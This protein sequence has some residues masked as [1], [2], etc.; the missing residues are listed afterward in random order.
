MSPQPSPI[1]H[2]RITAK[3]GEGGMGEVWRA[4]D[5]KLNREV[6]IKILPEAFAADPNRMARFTRE[7]QVLASLNHPN[8]AAIYGVEERALV[9]ELVEGPTLAER[10]GRGAMPLDEA[11]PIARQIAEALEYAHDRGVV[12]RDLKPANIK[13]T[14][15]GRVKVLDFGLAKA[16]ANESGA[17][18]PNISP[19]MTMSATMAGTIVG[20]AA[21]MSPEQARGHKV[22][23]RAD[24]WAFG[25]VLHEMLTGRQ[26]FAGPTISDSLAAV[27]K[28]DIDW[29]AVPVQARPMLKRCL[30]RDPRQRWHCIGDAAEALDD[31]HAPV[32]AVA[33]PRRATLWM[34]VAALLG[35]AAVAGWWMAWRATRPVE[36]P[37]TRLTVDLGPDALTGF[38]TTVA[39]SPDG[40]RLVFPARGPE[41]KQQLAT[42]LL[43]QEQITLLPGTEGG[44]DPFFS[45]DSQ[46]I[47][48]FANGQLKKLSLQGGVPLPLYGAP[49]P[50]GASW[51]EDGSIVVALTQL[52]QLTRIG[53][54]SGA[55]ERVTKLIAG[56]IGHR[57]P[58]VLPGGQTVL[59]TT[60]VTNTGADQSS[61]AAVS[62]KTGQTKVLLRG[63][64]FGRYVPPGWL[65]FVR[66][67]A[68]FGVRFNV[69]RLGV[70]GSPVP[71]VQDLAAN[72]M[73][74]GGQFEFSA[75]AGGSLVYLAGKGA[76]QNLQVAW[77]DGSGTMTPLLATPGTYS[78]PRFSPDGKKLMILSGSDIYVHDLERGTTTPMT[79]DNAV[80]PI[81][82]PDGKHIVNLSI[83]G[84]FHIIWRRSNGSGEP[85][86]LLDNLKYNV[87]PWSFSADGRRLAFS[88]FNPETGA[89]LWTVALDLTD[90][91][92][93]KAGTPE[94]FLRTPAEE[95]LPRFS[96]DGRWIAYRS[97]ESGRN[98]VYVRPFPPQNGGRWKVSTNGGLYALWSNDGR[99][100][101]YEADDNRIMV[102]DYTV[103]GDAFVSGKPRVWA[104][105]P[106][107]YAGVSNLDLAPDRK[108]FAVVIAPELNSAVKGSVRVTMLLNFLDE[109]KRKL[110]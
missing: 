22:D 47:G 54:A 50:R 23:R 8:I 62:L 35:L 93:P 63:G 97:N 72:P 76:A 61:I 17:G 43:D 51:G 37:L 65:V 4:T 39:I 26:L 16:M 69:D 3:L 49:T 104:D 52:S 87:I 94:L 68:L 24:I 36:H 21:Y 27:L 109:L 25:V 10:I 73:T 89:D 11:L 56:E 9:M 13:M 42:R 90:P 81:W 99:E 12:H 88:E 58:Q 107:F 41:G 78:V 95:V 34:A 101:F 83:T 74:G 110:P 82:T 91:D 53:G 55:P 77:M 70:Q 28:G 108:H 100:L 71:L 64:Y 20:S 75:E 33:P 14:P 66:Q 57:W 15:E 29:A 40:R 6:A 1:A 44:F 84:G 32:V 79:T 31:P 85:Y 45:P 80:S 7:A 102:V 98:E 92:R 67:G 19:T 86:T 59:F 46:S 106:L 5:T 96:Q 38:N 103:D 30:Q 105:R 2:Y 60:S 18:N 48:F